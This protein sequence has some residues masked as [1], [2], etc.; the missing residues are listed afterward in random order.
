[1]DGVGWE[2]LT[3]KPQLLGRGRRKGGVKSEARRGARSWN[4]APGERAVSLNPAG[5]R[6]PQAG[7]APL[8][9]LEVPPII[10]LCV[11]QQRGRNVV[12]FNKPLFFEL[13]SS[14][15]LCLELRGL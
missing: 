13:N 2:V 3:E 14:A 8:A 6:F 11:P 15:T 10:S 7:G 5:R 1:M 4:S 9:K 12:Q